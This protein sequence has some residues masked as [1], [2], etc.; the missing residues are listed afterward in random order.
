MVNTLLAKRPNSAHYLF[1]KGNLLNQQNQ[2][3][4]A[5][6]FLRA[7]L[8]LAPQDK[9]ILAAIGQSFN[10]MGNHER[11]EWFYRQAQRIAPQDIVTYF[12][13][14][15]NSLNAGDEQNVTRHTKRLF[16]TFSHKK[17]H[18]QL[19]VTSTNIFMPHYSL[20]IL[21][22]VITKKLEQISDG[23]HRG[24]PISE[25]DANFDPNDEFFSDYSGDR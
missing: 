18:A 1:L 23:I 11:A 6:K 8:R 20:E 24:N 14:I 21:E 7:A 22:P 5:L 25:D 15:E 9:K 16:T 4:K 12:C 2:P 17:I 13:L 19:K 10:K 3:A